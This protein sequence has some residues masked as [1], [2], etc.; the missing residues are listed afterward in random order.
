MTER[1]KAHISLMIATLL[2]GGNYW[3]SKVLVDILSPNQLVF[4]RSVGAFLLFAL[5]YFLGTRPKLNRSEL[6][7]LFVAGIFGIG[8]NQILF[9]SGLQY[10]TPVDTAIIHVSNPIIVLVLSLIFLHTKISWWKIA[11]IFIGAIGASILILY[12][13]DLVFNPETIKGNLMILGNTT[14][15]AIFLIVMKPILKK[16]DTI[17]TMFWVYL[18]ATLMIIPYSFSDMQTMQWELLWGW[19]LISLLYIIV[20]VTFGAYFLIIY[21]LGRLSA[22]VVS[23]YIY[24]QPLIAAIIATIIGVESLNWVNGLAAALIFTGVY[25]VNKNPAK[26]RV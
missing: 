22:P 20:M 13:K 21:S 15:Y 3:V 7:R 16:Y 1:R 11:G 17:T 24:L 10:T 4:F 2:F 9:F 8:I 19:P 5:V 18:F 26:E 12:Q 25:F 23:F 6:F 14:A